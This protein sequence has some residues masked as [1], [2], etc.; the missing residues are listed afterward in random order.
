MTLYEIARSLGLACYVR[1]IV[2]LD[3]EY[4][5]EGYTLLGNDFADYSAEGYQ[6]ETHDEKVEAI[7]SVLGE[8]E[9]WSS[10]RVTWI[11]HEEAVSMGKQATI[12]AVSSPLL[13]HK[14][15]TRT[16]SKVLIP[17][18]YGNQA[19]LELKYSHACLLI[20][21]PRFCE[22]FERRENEQR[23]IFEGIEADNVGNNEYDHEIDVCQ[24]PP[25][26][27]MDYD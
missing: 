24:F 10:R 13:A 26:E 11:N 3:N 21:V 20:R 22:R 2:E 15:R 18:Q 6:L 16:S 12:I 5:G 25:D 8:S 14:F 7:R 27:D 1:P 23:G 9:K 17:I 4:D 19:E